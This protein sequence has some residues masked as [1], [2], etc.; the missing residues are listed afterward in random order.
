[1]EL[2]EGSLEVVVR[3]KEGGVPLEPQEDLPRI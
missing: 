1:M 3:E 2:M